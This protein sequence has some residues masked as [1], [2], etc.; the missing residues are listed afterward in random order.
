[1]HNH[2]MTSFRRIFLCIP[3]IA[4][5]G[6]AFSAN[7]DYSYRANPLNAFGI[8]HSE[9]LEAGTGIT[10]RNADR[11][12]VHL[13]LITPPI[14]DDQQLDE[15]VADLSPELKDLLSGPLYSEQAGHPG[16]SMESMPAP[17]KHPSLNQKRNLP[18]FSVLLAVP[19]DAKLRLA[20]HSKHHAFLEAPIERLLSDVSPDELIQDLEG[21][22]LASIENEIRLRDLRLV[23]LQI[24]PFQRLSDVSANRLAQHRRLEIEI[25]FERPNSPSRPT[26]TDW[27]AP[28]TKEDSSK[29]SADWAGSASA[30]ETCLKLSRE[31]DQMQELVGDYVLNATNVAEFMMLTPRNKPVLDSEQLHDDAKRSLEDES[32]ILQSDHSGRRLRLAVVDEGIYSL[33][34]ADLIA[35]GIAL[36]SIDID[37][38]AMR[39][40]TMPIAMLLLGTEDM[41]FDAED[42]I[43]FYGRPLPPGAETLD[44]MGRE[45]PV[46]DGDRQY[47]HENPYWL[48]LDSDSGS[49]IKSL[50]APPEASSALEPY[51]RASVWRSEVHRWWSTHFDDDDPWFWNRFVGPEDSYSGT[52]TVTLNAIAEAGRPASVHLRFA[53]YSGGQRLTKAAMNGE[54]NHIGQLEWQGDGRDEFSAEFAA[55]LLREGENELIIENVQSQNQFFMFDDFTLTYDRRFEPMEHALAFDLEKT[56]TQRR[57][58]VGPF[59]DESLE[60]WDISDPAQPLRIEKA[61]VSTDGA[62]VQLEFGAKSDA[63]RYIVADGEGRKHPESIRLVKPSDLRASDRSADH[64]IIAPKAFLEQAQRLAAHRKSQGMRTAVVDLQEVYDEFGAGQMHPRA[65]RNFLR[66][67]YVNWAK[68]AP[69]YAVLVG[70]GHWNPHAFCRG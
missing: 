14:Q 27:Q 10:L 33:S 65:I 3:A 37:R 53:S 46:R 29:R 49:H 67:A 61:Q 39:E 59:E 5:L 15:W 34:G 31:A 7:S 54:S 23:R 69:S 43:L 58:E 13:Q 2:R 32:R 50:E 25:D 36:D 47:S 24:Q 42:Q 21:S 17:V 57:V 48:D 52:Y 70:D 64:I 1:M 38:L 20:T 28:S 18:S 6:I 51:Y 35:A 19:A 66:Y 30:A 12:G 55:S 11:G 63:A 22:A 60:L 40:R 41:R 4:L 62:G 56:D 8:T 45:V 26:C 9:N 44:F 68:P 16:P